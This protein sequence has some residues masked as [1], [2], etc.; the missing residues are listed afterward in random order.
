MT[1]DPIAT[2]LAARRAYVAAVAADDAATAAYRVAKPA[3]PSPAADEATWTA[4]DNADDDA[5]FAAGCAR[6]SGARVAACDA[7]LA[8][9]PA[10]LGSSVAVSS[11]AMRDVAD[12]IDSVLSGR[13]PK[14][15]NRVV[16]LALRWQPSGVSA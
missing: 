4:Y 12:V 7:M 1:T 15:L 5:W 11:N 9:M 10:A 14:A 2:F 13:A 6:T 3:D 8:A 16:D